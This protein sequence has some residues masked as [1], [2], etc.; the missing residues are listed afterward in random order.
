MLLSLTNYPHVP[1]SFAQCIRKNR[2]KEKSSRE[3]G[4]TR[5]VEKKKKKKSLEPTPSS[6][7]SSHLQQLLLFYFLRWVLVRNPR[8][9][10]RLVL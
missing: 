4:K 7:S 2:E 3:E 8:F 6:S 5:L 1:F 9:S 10:R